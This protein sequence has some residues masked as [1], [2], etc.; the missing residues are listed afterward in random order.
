MILRLIVISSVGLSLII[1]TL[2]WPL[3]VKFRHL[4][5]SLGTIL[6]SPV[7]VLFYKVY[8][9]VLPPL[10]RSRELQDEVADI[11]A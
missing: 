11:G 1:S 5:L 3:R 8:A 6:M 10:Y 7:L 2:F 9:T 4:L